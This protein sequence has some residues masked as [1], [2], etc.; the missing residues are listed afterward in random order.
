VVSRVNPDTVA[1]WPRPA[2]LLV[3]LYWPGLYWMGFPWTGCAWPF[4]HVS[5]MLPNVD[6]TES[7]II[8]LPI[9][10]THAH[11]CN[12]NTRHIHTHAPTSTSLRRNRR[13]DKLKASARDEYEQ[14]KNENDPLI[15]TRYSV[16]VRSTTRTHSTR[17]THST[18]STQHRPS[19]HLPTQCLARRPMPLL[20]PTRIPLSHSLSHSLSLPHSLFLSLVRPTADSSSMGA[21]R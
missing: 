12:H 21:T 11:T 9:T 4:A 18:Y 7:L 19:H 14:A 3:R 15:I 1:S 20:S 16:A 13:A 17:S 6:I 2:S 5:G 8:P 10:H